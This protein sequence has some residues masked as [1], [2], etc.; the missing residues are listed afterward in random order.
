PLPYTKLFRSAKTMAN[1]LSIPLFTLPTLMALAG[2]VQATS[3]PTLIVPFIDARRKTAF[4]TVYLREG[5]RFTPLF[6][7]SHGQFIQFL[8]QVETYFKINQDY[9]SLHITF[10]SPTIDA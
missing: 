8:D 3:G 10:V 1:T 2:N 5:N 4:A 6:T 9:Q 7:T